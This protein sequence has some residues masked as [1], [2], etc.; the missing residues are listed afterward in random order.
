MADLI[1]VELRND[2]SAL[3]VRLPTYLLFL[4]YIGWLIDLFFIIFFIVLDQVDFIDNQ[5]D[6]GILGYS[7]VDFFQYFSNFD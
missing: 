4:D 7:L 3:K 6:Y 5:K 2:F 1:D